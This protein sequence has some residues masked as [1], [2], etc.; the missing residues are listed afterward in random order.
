[1]F[2]PNEIPLV[3]QSVTRRTAECRGTKILEKLPKGKLPGNPV[4]HEDIK[5]TWK[6]CGHDMVR[7][8][9]VLLTYKKNA[10]I[11]ETCQS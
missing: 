3:P 7:L 1:M 4:K 2:I 8:F 6:E 9:N 11:V 10:A 5:A